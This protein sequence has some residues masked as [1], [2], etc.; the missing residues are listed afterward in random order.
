MYYLDTILDV[1][2]KDVTNA[3][4]SFYVWKH[5]HSI[6]SDKTEVLHALNKNP[7]SWRVITHSL[8]TTFLITFGRLFDNDKRSITAE[9]LLSMCAENL[10]QFGGEALKDRKLKTIGGDKPDWLDDFVSNAYQPTKSDLE[11]LLT[12]VLAKKEIYQKGYA[13]IRN[14]IM[15]HR[16]FDTIAKV[17]KLFEKTEIGQIQEMLDFL[18][19]IEKVIFDL[20][21]NGKLNPIGNYTF[22][23][24][25]RVQADVESLLGRVVSG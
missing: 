17:D 7:I 9:K 20:L 15:A 21:Y 10:E 19:Q 23:E 8:Q 25:E 13:P 18:F 16:D 6:A 1:Y 14:K 3:V 2:G 11:S 4:W 5:I 24:E 12:K 22:D